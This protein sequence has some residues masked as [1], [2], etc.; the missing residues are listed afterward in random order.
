[1]AR[2]G[3]AHDFAHDLDRHLKL[4]ASQERSRERFATWQAQL[5]APPAQP[6]V[7]DQAP[8]DVPAAWKLA[9][10]NAAY[11]AVLFWQAVRLTAI[12]ATGRYHALLNGTLD[13]KTR[14]FLTGAS[15]GGWACT[16]I[17][18]ALFIWR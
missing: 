11:A 2:N 15:V 1:M 13:T 8:A 3:F 16:L 7:I 10:A 5:S 9:A 18:I 4:V 12:A 6:V 14:D 17:L